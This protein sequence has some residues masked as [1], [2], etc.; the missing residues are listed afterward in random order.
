MSNGALNFVRNLPAV[1]LGRQPQYPLLFSYDITHRCNLNCRYCCD[2]DGKRFFQ[3]E[4]IHELSTAEAKRLLGIL[5]RASD[6][7]DI[8]GGEPL[9]R[10]DLGEILGEAKRLRFKTVLNTKAISIQSRID[11]LRSADLIIVGID[12]LNAD[13]LAAVIGRPKECAERLLE[14]LRFLVEHRREYGYSVALSTVATPDNLD[15]VARVLNFAVE[16]RLGFHVSPEILGTE[17]NRALIGNAKYEEL[18]DKV[19]LAKRAGGAILGV[20]QYLIGI[21][22]FTKFQCYPLLMPVIRP[23]GR[24][25]YPCLETKCAEINVLEA[26]DYLLALKQARATCGEIPKCGNC[27][28]I[29]CHMGASLLQRHPVAALRELRNWGA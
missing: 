17:A 4:G 27:C 18:I 16:H 11:V 21:K 2:G 29:F 23:D 13:A 5:R 8:T 28:H 25:Y 20:E 6:T 7:L 14:G 9:L 10:E 26:G 24:L 22:Y 1:A 3:E 12:T 15:D 19:R